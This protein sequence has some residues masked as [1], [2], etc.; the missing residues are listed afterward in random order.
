MWQR[1]ADR[2]ALVQRTNYP[3]EPTA[4]IEINADKPADF[5]VMLRVP[6]W[7]GAKTA[8]AVNGKRWASGPEPGKFA[9]INRTWKNGDRMEIEFDMPTVLE[10]VDPEHPNLLA[11]VYG[12]LVLFSVGDVPSS[13]T[14]RELAA[15]SQAATRSTDWQAKSAA[16][17]L[18]L[19]PFAAI[20]D[21][22]YRLYLKLDG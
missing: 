19:R 11:A 8:I 20:R 17:T 14:K 9:S 3:Y 13:L 18:M 15:A 10:A 22:H 16:G 1:G 4:A 12:P 7:A 5:A 6:A 2:I 21:E